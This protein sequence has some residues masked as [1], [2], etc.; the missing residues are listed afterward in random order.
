[1]SKM[2][3]FNIADSFINLHDYRICPGMLY[4][5]Y[6]TTIKLPYTSQNG[7]AKISTKTYDLTYVVE[8]YDSIRDETDSTNSP[9]WHTVRFWTL[10]TGWMSPCSLYRPCVSGKDHKF[11]IACAE[12]NMRINAYLASLDELPTVQRMSNRQ[13]KKMAFDTKIRKIHETEKTERE[14][15]RDLGLSYNIGRTS[16]V[17]PAYSKPSYDTNPN[18]ITDTGF[19][20]IAP[21]KTMPKGVVIKQD[22]PEK[23]KY[24]TSKLSKEDKKE[25]KTVYI[26]TCKKDSQS[27]SRKVISKKSLNASIKAYTTQG[28]KVDYCFS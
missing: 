8:S 19:V 21:P 13:R 6:H 16:E 7:E 11:A 27:F 18:V 14:L 3:L 10:E 2:T 5:R 23:P 26:I 24:N 25:D 4:G 12:L 15:L 20:G 1:M 22:K 28:W 9:A 17:A